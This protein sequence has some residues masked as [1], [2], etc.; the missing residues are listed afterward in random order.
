M[1]KP[2]T[3]RALVAIAGLVAACGGSDGST[4]T[5]PN[6]LVAPV[7][8]A[9]PDSAQIITSDLI[10]F[11][12]AYDAGGKNG[13]TSAFQ[14]KYLDVASYGLADFIRSRS[15]TASSL[16]QMVGAF[17][18]YFAS[19][20]ATNL[21]L[22]TDST[23]VARLRANFTTIKKLYPPARFPPVTLLIGRFSTGGTTS[24]NGMLIGSE[25]YSTT[26]GTPLDEL[27][28]FQRDNVKNADSLPTSSLTNTRTS[29]RETWR[30]VY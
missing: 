29:C 15:I 14:A 30:A 11:W 18:K 7:T 24:A 16:A 25:F 28:Q 27:Q 20:R 9:D 19:I 13:S 12:D 2:A 10:H 5:A 23:I 22:A 4:P 3:I 6:P 21:R 17:P 26:A 8:T 1:T